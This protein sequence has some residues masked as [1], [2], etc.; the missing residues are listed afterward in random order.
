M[1]TR[2]QQQQQ[3]WHHAACISGGGCSTRRQHEGGCWEV[4]AWPIRSLP[5][6]PPLREELLRP[7]SHSYRPLRAVYHQTVTGHHPSGSYV[8][9]S[10]WATIHVVVTTCGAQQPLSSSSTALAQPAV[11]EPAGWFPAALASRRVP[12]LCAC[13]CGRGFYCCFQAAVATSLQLQLTGV[14][15]AA[16]VLLANDLQEA[17][18]PAAAAAA[19]SDAQ[20]AAAGQDLPGLV[21]LAGHHA[22][23]LRAACN[24]QPAAI[25]H[26]GSPAHSKMHTRAGAG[27]QLGIHGLPPHP[28]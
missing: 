17:P 6:A 5:K 3:P 24:F 28:I 16:A 15:A 7:H 26:G 22:P 4:G 14:R 19:A 21:P 25:D 12:P 18:Q 23:E 13:Q 1:S 9:R 20:I 27:L 10:L 8:V 2:S 11:R